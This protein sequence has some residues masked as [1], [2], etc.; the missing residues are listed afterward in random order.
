VTGR[1][2]ELLLAVS[3]R[4]LRTKVGDV[5]HWDSRVVGA[6][7]D[8]IPQ[9]IE[10]MV[11]AGSSSAEQGGLTVIISFDPGVELEAARSDRPSS[12]AIWE[13]QGQEGY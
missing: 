1:D 5:P 4:T 11:K 3:G 7:H 10:P 2:L 13:A 9:E 6:N 12:T 8:R